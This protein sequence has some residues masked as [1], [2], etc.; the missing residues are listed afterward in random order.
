[1]LSNTADRAGQ[2]KFGN[3]DAWSE[4]LVRS[5]EVLIFFK[6]L[7]EAG[8]G[9][10]TIE[11]RMRKMVLEQKSR[12]SDRVGSNG[13]GSTVEQGGK[14]KKKSE[15]KVDARDVTVVKELLDIKIGMIKR[16]VREVHKKY[17]DCWSRMEDVVKKNSTE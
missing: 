14:V 8:V 6:E 3:L 1:M 16:E 15:V 11:G 12:Y 17:R 13:R 9:T 10:G 2:T 4:K 7:R 5:Q